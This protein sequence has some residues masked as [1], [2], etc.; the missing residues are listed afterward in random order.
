MIGCNTAATAQR[1][2]S[3]FPALNVSFNMVGTLSTL[4][5]LPTCEGWLF[6]SRRAWR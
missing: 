1:L 4:A 3:T 2:I 6:L 5:G